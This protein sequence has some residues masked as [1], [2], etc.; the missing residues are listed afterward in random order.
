V[1]FGIGSAA[2]NT[3]YQLC[4]HTQIWFPLHKLKKE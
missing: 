4:A 3:T 2:K 1:N